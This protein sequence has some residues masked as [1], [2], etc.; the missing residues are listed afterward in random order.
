[1][2]RPSVFLQIKFVIIRHTFLLI[3]Y[4]LCLQSYLKKNDCNIMVLS[5]SLNLKDR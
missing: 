1:M 3:L 4:F 5:S 2:V